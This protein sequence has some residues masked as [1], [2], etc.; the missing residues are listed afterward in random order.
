MV[1]DWN[2]LFRMSRHFDLKG[3][4]LGLSGCSSKEKSVLE[5]LSTFLVCENCFSIE[6]ETM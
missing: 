5:Q 6:S 3:C 1:G 4:G 2:L